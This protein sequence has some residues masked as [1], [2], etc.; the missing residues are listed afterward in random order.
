MQHGLPA[1]TAASADQAAYMKEDLAIFDGWNLSVAEM[2][3]LDR[4]SFANETTVKTMCTH[5]I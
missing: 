2:A 1:I 5:G 4:A 3:A